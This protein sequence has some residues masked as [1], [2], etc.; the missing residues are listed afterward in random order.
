MI[1]PFSDEE[2]LLASNR[3]LAQVRATLTND[4]GDAE[5]VRVSGTKVFVRL[6]GACVGCSSSNSTLK[7]VIERALK[8]NI[9]PDMTVI[10][11]TNMEQ[12]DV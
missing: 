3:A 7:W 4:G 1:F 12:T 2:I 5:I 8:V 10:D 9:H 11:A 6:K